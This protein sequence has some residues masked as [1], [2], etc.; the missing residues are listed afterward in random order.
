MMSLVFVYINVLRSSP[1]AAA[2]GRQAHRDD[3]DQ[4]RTRHGAVGPTVE[5]SGRR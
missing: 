1:A 2:D 5:R 3:T 4:L